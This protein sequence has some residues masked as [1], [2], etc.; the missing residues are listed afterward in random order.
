[1]P[2]KRSLSNNKMEKLESPIYLMKTDFSL[3]VILR[4][5]IAVPTSKQYYK[6]NLTSLIS[7][8]YPKILRLKYW[9]RLVLTL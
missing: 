1:M 8:N 7:K 9:N 3:N 5:L 4:N 2:T 6:T